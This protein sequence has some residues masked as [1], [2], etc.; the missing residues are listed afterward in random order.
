MLHFLSGG[1]F[2]Y[3]FSVFFNPIKDTFQWTSAQ[4]S[5]AFTLRSVE[6]GALGPIAG[7]LVDKLGPR[8]L[9]VAGWI[10]IGVGFLLMSRI[11]SLATF[12]ITFIIVATGTSFGSGVVMNTA[13]ANWFTKKR[14]RAM[15]I[16]FIGPGVCG[17]IA[18]LLAYFIGWIGWRDTLVVMGITLLV[19]GIPL[20]LLFRH[21]PDQY[22]Y[23]PD[24]EVLIEAP[25][26]AGGLSPSTTQETV[27]HNSAHQAIGFTVK[28]AL[29]TRAF[30]MLSMAFFFQQ[31]G[32]S[33]V[34]VHIVAYLES[35]NVPTSIAALAVTGMT[36]CS[37]IGRVGFGILG[38][39]TNKRYLIALSLGLQAIGLFLF[40]IINADKVWLLL[41]FL[42]TF[43]PG[44]G[45]PIPLRPALQADFFGTKSY[46]TIM[47]L[48]AVIS[49]IGG[50]ASPVFAGWIFDITGSYH[51]AWQIFT[52]IILPA[53]PLVLL[54]R[55]PKLPGDVHY[56]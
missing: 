17:L 8:K 34:T 6:T 32:A 31:M 3:G 29:R 13:I 33:A 49:T 26:T 52:V 20:S 11:N 12:Y 44:F 1:A 23:L 37:L 55:P 54:T 27:T 9:M 15:A 21:K 19:T 53:I 40:S 51:I 39:F 36:L 42:L 41:L 56:R 47:G 28:E 2:Y 4:T 43:G 50:L 7:L 38:D 14:S 16:S 24:G 35:V 18:P 22:G 25:A 45:G 5:L 10:V 48:M 46:G 30:W